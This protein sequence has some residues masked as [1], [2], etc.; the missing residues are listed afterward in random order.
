MAKK[1]APAQ[2]TTQDEELP[3]TAVKPRGKD[4]VIQSLQE[5]LAQVGEEEPSE[6]QETTSAEEET[7]KKRYGDLRRHLQQKETGFN[8]R[9]TELEA[10]INQLTKLSN[11]PMPSTK[12]EFEA[13]KTKYP[14][15]ASFIEII[16][17]EKANA[18][19]SQLNEELSGVKEKLVKTE[20]ERAWATLLSLVPD[21]EELVKSDP[22]RKW[23]D[24]QPAFVQEELNTSEDPHRVAYW[25]GV[26]RA[27]TNKPAP[28]KTN[29]LAALDT[30][31]KNSG[32]TPGPQSGK[33]KFTTSQISKMSPQD[34]EKM[35][36]EIVAARNAG[37]ILDDMKRHQTVFE[38]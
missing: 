23:L 24:D 36:D 16:A 25:I 13:W 17:D 12:E 14:Q 37:Q 5:R 31:M 38:V 18:R 9:V 30:S 6:P 20:Q 34:F 1:S 26:Y 22:Y 32:V 19:A 8:Q 15:I 35:E 10:Q 29:K 4:L 27:A 33:W 21:V 28:A 11:A 7:F 2:A 3:Q